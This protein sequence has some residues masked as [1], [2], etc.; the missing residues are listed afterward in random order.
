M[1]G[2][3][4]PRRPRRV[5]GR[6]SPGGAPRS[7]A[8]GRRAPPRTDRAAPRRGVT[9]PPDGRS[10]AASRTNR[11]GG[12]RTAPRAGRMT[13][14][15][16]PN[17]APYGPNEA[18]LRAGRRP[19]TGLG[20]TAVRAA[21]HTPRTGPAQHRRTGRT[22]PPCRAA[23]HPRGRIRA[24]TR[25]HPVGRAVRPGTVRLRAAPLRAGTGSRVPRGE[26]A[27]RGW[28]NTSGP[29]ASPGGPRARVP[30]PARHVRT[31]VRVY[32]RTGVR[33]DPG[34]RGRGTTRAGLRAT[35]SGPRRGSPGGRPATGR[36]SPS[37]CADR[38]PAAG[39]GRCSRRR[40]SP[41]AAPRW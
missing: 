6:V 31:G 8:P 37:A 11:A 12:L 7:S 35:A 17:N 30:P 32:G 19:L 18:P 38:S 34:V 13:F 33:A 25:R 29:G 1:K 39:T 41:P 16:G 9:R 2:V 20:G 4:P 10:P 24:P 22:T 28:R 36:P 23:Q 21:Q 3:R 5:R 15:Y 26:G 14:P 27:P 40:R